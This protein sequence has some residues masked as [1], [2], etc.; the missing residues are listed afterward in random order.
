LIL[1][2]QRNICKES[3]VSVCTEYEPVIAKPAGGPAAEEVLSYDRK[4]DLITVCSHLLFPGIHHRVTKRLVVQS[5]DGWRR[6]KMGGWRTEA[7]VWM[8]VDEDGEA[9]LQQSTT[10][11]RRTSDRSGN[12]DRPWRHHQAPWMPTWWKRPSGGDLLYAD[13]VAVV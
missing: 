9:Q 10:R 3:R 1:H 7:F 5:V 12:A 4:L 13:L 2:V 6:K 8:G 11:S